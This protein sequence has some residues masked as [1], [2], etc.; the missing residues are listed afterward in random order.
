MHMGVPRWFRVIAALILIPLL[1]TSCLLGRG[2]VKPAITITSPHNGD[3]VIVG[4]A[5]NIESLALDDEGIARVELW[6]DGVRE[7]SDE[8]APAASSA[9]LELAQQWMPT[10]AGR[11]K[12]SVRAFNLEGVGSDAAIVLIEAVAAQSAAAVPP[13]PTPT[14]PPVSPTDT[15]APIPTSANCMNNASFVADITVPDDSSYHPGEAFEKIW[16]M[17]NSGSCPWEAGYT[18]VFESGDQMGANTVAGVSPTISSADA[19]IRITLTA[20]SEP[21]RYIGRWRMHDL[22]NQPFGQRA[23][24]VINVLPADLDVP[25]AP[26]NLLA[27]QDEAGI[28]LL[29]WVDQSDNEQGF[30]VYSADDTALLQT[31]DAADVTETEI[32]NVPCDADVAFIVRAYNEAG[33]SAAS[34]PA[35]LRTSPCQANRPVIHYFQADPGAIDP[36]QSSVLTWDLAG[37]LEA[38]LFPGGEGGVVAP[39]SITVSPAESTTYRLVATN[40][41]GTVEKKVTVTVR[42]VASVAPK[43]GISVSAATVGERETFQITVDGSVSSGMDAI[44]WWGT[45]INDPELKSIH[46]FECQGQTTCSEK[47]DVR[48][49]ISGLLQFSANGRSVNGVQGGQAGQLPIATVR[50]VPILH[51]GTGVTV[52]AKQCLDMESGAIVDCAGAN[53]DVRWIQDPVDGWML[54]GA[55]GATMAQ[56]GVQPSLDAVGYQSAAGS[57]A[58]TTQVL[59]GR[60]DGTQL[61]AGSLLAIRT[62]EG[63]LGKVLI[64]SITE[65]VQLDLVTYLE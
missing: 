16:R 22:A 48:A 46:S 45:D 65:S 37:A 9:S 53:A 1:S 62:N 28:I 38:R 58:F 42:S 31:I 55:N 50:V 35:T 36:G 49:T 60:D 27:E 25:K 32:T 43:M 23:T 12:I 7:R 17:R 4:Q 29:S 20:P 13:T 40:A 41:S 8:F 33:E 11:Y 14:V 56:L 54:V 5:V 18:W 10:S 51:E 3:Q 57:P 64:R 59:V 2:P 63:R 61:T 52:K 6:V 26:T 39:G 19:D 47:W 15:P 34:G 24:V 44:W 30:K 21:G